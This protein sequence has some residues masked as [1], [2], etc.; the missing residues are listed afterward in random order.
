MSMGLLKNKNVIIT[1]ATRGIGKAIS[2]VFAS[3]GATIA[4]V[5]TNE[6]RG[7]EVVELLNETK[8]CDDQRFSFYKLDVRN[9]VDVKLTVDKILLEWDSVVDILVNCAGVTKDGLLIRMDE[10]DWDLVIDTNLKS[11]YNLSRVVVRSMMRKGSG[12]IINISSVSGLVG[13]PGQ[14]NYSASKSGMMGMTRSMAMEL[15]GKKILVNCIAPGFIETDMT[16]K[17]SDTQ[18]EKILNNIPLK[19]FGQAKDVAMTALFLA[20][21][22]SEYITGQT[23]VVDGGMT[24]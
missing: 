13:V 24:A 16:S 6:D 3:Q 14:A 1:G 8:L 12:R 2:K 23:I 15:A 7:R 20:C 4:A 9:S 21:D 19:R 11:V 17:L 18:K 5:G 10:E 22:H